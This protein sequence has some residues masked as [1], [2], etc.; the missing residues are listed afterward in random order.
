MSR[1]TTMV[2]RALAIVLI[3]SSASILRAQSAAPVV[4]FI[5]GLTVTHAVR[6]LE[7]DYESMSALGAIDATGAPLTV[8]ADAPQSSGGKVVQVV[9]TRT[10]RKVDLASARTYKYMFT[11][12]DEPAYPGT[13]AIELSA[14][15]I[16]DLR[17]RGQTEI[18]LDGRGSGGLLGA[19]GDLMGSM[20][21]SGGLGGMLSGLTGDARIQASG[22]VKLVEPRPVGVSVILNGKRTTLPAYHVRGHVGTADAG[23]DADLYVLDDPANPLVLRETIAKDKVEVI[24]IDFP[25]ADAPKT[26][27]RELADTRRT[28]VYGIYFDFNS[29]TIKPQSESV[30]REIVAV[31]KDQ[32]TWTLKVEGH[33]DNVGGDAKNQDLS[34]RRAAA[35]KDALVQRGVPA[36]RL[37]TGGY[38]AS[39]PRETNATLAGRARNRRVE[40]SRQ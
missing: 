16:N 25:V 29:A 12:N 33:T 19:V 1:E 28:A 8:S 27:E 9:V 18:T 4:P 31:M 22:V 30:L 32:P 7:G 5:Q 21:K 23:E 40:L 15:M 2:T 11:T 35:V 37:T 3:S 39:V 17:A 26:M 34:A 14:L 36:G 6:A 20:D 24:K 38:G 13:T 10:L